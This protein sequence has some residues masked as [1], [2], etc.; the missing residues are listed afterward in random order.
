MLVVAGS[1]RTW[2]Q[3]LMIAVL[4]SG[5]FASL[6]GPL[7]RCTG[8]T[9]SPRGPSRS[10]CPEGDWSAIRTF[11]LH[12]AGPLDDCDLTVVDGIPTTNIA[13]TLCDLGA[14]VSDDLVEQA[15]DDALRRRCSQR[16]IEE[17]LARLDRPGP[18]GTGALRRV[19]ARPDRAGRLPDSAFERL[20]ERA[21][22][23]GGLPLPERQHPIWDETGALIARIDVAWPDVLIGVE[24]TS[25]QWHA[26]PRRGRAG[27]IRHGKLT[28]RGWAMFYPGWED[29][30]RPGPFVADVVRA[31]R[32]RRTVA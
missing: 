11:V 6:T 12:H 24:A 10:R 15:F 28:G 22:A 25:D 32:S 13:R 16:W 14:V 3:A 30:K 20:I 8:S 4:R 27:L 9:V 5:G 2:R 31:Y 17:T 29:S 26:G 19:L 1:P 23:L 18:S 7:P 21:I